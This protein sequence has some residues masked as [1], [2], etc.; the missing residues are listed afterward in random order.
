VSP[1]GLLERDAELAELTGWAREARRRGRVV[2]VAGEA[3]IGKTSLVDAFLAALPGSVP[4]LR[5]ACE[6][7][8]TPRP[9]APLFDLAR[10][11]SLLAGGA[12]PITVVRALLDLL[13]ERAGSVLVVEDLHWADDATLDL[14]RHLARRVGEARALVVVTV[15]DDELGDRHPARVALG[16]IAP[17]RRITLSGLSR[18]AVARLAGTPEVDALFRRTRGNPFFVTESLA[19]GTALPA[20]VSDAVLA[21]AARLP[22]AARHVLDVA[23][24]LGTARPALLL[25]AAGGAGGDLNR[26]V[27]AGL[28]VEDDVGTAFRHDLARSAVVAAIPPGRR[29]ELHAAVLAVLDDAGAAS[30]VL[31]HHAEAAGRPAAALH[32]A[33]RAAL[34]AARLGAHRQAAEQYARALR[35]LPGDADGERAELLVLAS[36]EWALCDEV[37]RAT[38]DAEAALRLRA[39]ARDRLREGDLLAWLSRLAWMSERV[40]AAEA[41]ARHAVEVLDELP[42]GVELARAMATLAQQLATDHGRPEALPWGLRALNL[43]ERLG[44]ADIAAQATIDIGLTRALAADPEG[45]ALIREGIDR[46]RAAGS[47]DHAARGAFQLVRVANTVLRADEA[48]AAAAAATAFCDERG[49]PFWGDYALALHAQSLLLRGD[50]DAAADRAGEVWRRTRPTSPAVRSTVAAVTLGLVALRRGEPAGLLDRAAEHAA[51]LPW[52]AGLGIAAALA[53]R[54]WLGGTLP[55]FAAE[56]RRDWAVRRHCDG[57]WNA[58][59]TWWLQVAGTPAEPQAGFAQAVAGGWRAAADGFRDLGLPYHRA[60]ALAESPEEAPLREAL[61]IAG[62]FDA[63]PLG[64]LVA[65]RLRALGARNIPRQR[66]GSADRGPLSPREREVLTL[67][68]EGL[69]DAEIAARLHVSERTVHHHVS[70]VLRKLAAPSRTAAVAVALREGLLPGEMGSSAHPP[71]VPGS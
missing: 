10:L 63:R 60:L 41:L 34:R 69:R 59:L 24:V 30:A 32:H 38:A 17:T 1:S 7:L 65:R 29:V 20:T 54:A 11:R 12:E 35:A 15:R 14:L 27:A 68:A 44:A 55:A 53:E 71:T 57:W 66:S 39:A 16:D 70:A 50:W 23:A 25:A 5:G 42:P 46:A 2:L 9:L 6:A 48:D 3:G 22:A 31:A 51:P 56:L 64:R 36:R 37:A 61:E 19:A 62:S 43:A 49:V 4:V 40:A 67:L 33:R 8:S 47:D 45:V 13:A 28:L 21:R 52:R 26:C 18:A 58:E